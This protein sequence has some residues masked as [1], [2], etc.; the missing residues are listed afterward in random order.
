[1]LLVKE[2]VLSLKEKTLQHLFFFIQIA[3]NTENL[4]RLTR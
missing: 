3:C 1:M 4:L 2:T